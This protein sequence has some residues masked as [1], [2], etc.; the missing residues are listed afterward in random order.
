MVRMPNTTRLTA[1]LTAARVA[2]YAYVTWSW[3]FS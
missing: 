1:G 2:G 3:R